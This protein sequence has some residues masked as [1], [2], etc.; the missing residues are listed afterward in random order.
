M[1]DKQLLDWLE[2]TG[3][4][5]K[6]GP[7]RVVYNPVRDWW[8]VVDNLGPL[9]YRPTLREALELCAHASV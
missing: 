3:L 9:Y 7:Y 4:M 5:T 6:G 1:T 2:R 8:A